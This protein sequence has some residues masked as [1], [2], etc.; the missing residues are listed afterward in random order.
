MKGNPNL[1]LLRSIA[2]SIVVVQHVLLT[3][4]VRQLGPWLTANLGIVGV[5]MFFVH[6][7]LV[8]IWSL[9]RRP[10]ALDFYIRRVFR[11]Y[12]IAVLAITVTV[13]FHIPSLH[14]LSGDTFYYAPS[15]KNLVANLFLVQ[16]IIWHG[17]ILGVMW[18]LP[19]E[20]DM[21]LLLPFLYFVS[22]GK[23]P[24]L[25]IGFLWIA[26]VI[27]DSLG[28]APDDN[29]LAVCIPYFLAGVLAS[30]LFGRV[31]Q[32]ISGYLLPLFLMILLCCYLARPGLRNGW[33]LTLALGLILPLFRPI[34]AKW[35]V[36]TSHEIAKYS[37]GIYLIH[38]F[39]I[40]IGFELLPRSSL[41]L[42]LTGVLVSLAALVI[43]TYH[44]V[45]K[46]MIDLGA[47]IAT[48][49]REPQPMSASVEGT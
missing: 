41:A 47:R 14:N 42:R 34:R 33:W 31:K 11:I 23:S 24:L 38:P 40:V 17:N 5:Y 25:R 27:F 18:T 29:S 20:M 10:D 13:L 48:R 22:L 35:L 36:N 49:L 3:A 46:P 15:L 16:N 43:P 1:D 2:V 9:R 32:R 19:L 7:A 21:Y 6:T 12:P 37:Y 8:L 4:H 44:F 39:C 45:E 26:V 28:L 30:I